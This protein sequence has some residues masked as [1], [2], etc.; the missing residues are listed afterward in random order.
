[1][2]SS[3]QQACRSMGKEIVKLSELYSFGRD[4]NHAEQVMRLLLTFCLS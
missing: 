1:M 2:A 4:E 3:F